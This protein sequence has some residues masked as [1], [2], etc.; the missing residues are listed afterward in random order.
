MRQFKLF[1]F[2]FSFLIISCS[3]LE[4]AEDLITGLSE[5]ERYKKD[6]NVSDEIFEIW[7]SRLEKGL[8]DSIEVELPYSESGELKPRNF[9]IYAYEIYLMPGEVLE[10]V[11]ETDSSSTLIFSSLYKKTSEENRDFE[12]IVAG[13]AQQRSLKFEIQ[14]KGLYKLILQPEIEANTAFNIKILKAPA[15]LFPVSNGKNSDIGSYYGDMREGGKRDHKG[16]DIFAERGTPVIATT[17]GRIGFTGEKGLGGKQIWLRDSK[18]KLSV[19]YAH[20]DSIKPDLKKVLPGDTLGFV[21]NTGNARTTPPHLHFGI[22]KRRYGTLD[23]LGF[24]YQVEE[25]EEPRQENEIVSRV[26]VN[27][28]RANFRNKPASNNSEILKTGKYGELLFVQGKTADWFHVR[29]SLDRSMFI[30]ESQ[31]QSAY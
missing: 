4:K 22:Y 2:L 26:K 20:L 31:V 29:D 9:A 24:V 14:E 8:G 25:L 6:A 18:R 16:I 13:E 17:A 19:Y 27:S 28:K 5:K 12:E 7:E 11:V 3:Q 21:G 30:H 1:L 23:P 15:Y 10:A